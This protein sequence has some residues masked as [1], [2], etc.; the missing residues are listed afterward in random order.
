MPIIAPDRNK[1][2]VAALIIQRAGSNMNEPTAEND[3]NGE[4]KLASDYEMA[5]G[6]A[7]LSMFKALQAGNGKAAYKYYKSAH[8]I[9][10]D[11][12]ESLE[13]EEEME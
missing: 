12:L 8:K 1:G 10:D 11:E 4:G 7:L 5:G 2:K 3:D 6:E 9:C 13:P